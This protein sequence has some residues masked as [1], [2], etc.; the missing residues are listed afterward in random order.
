M[1]NRI[2]CVMLISIGHYTSAQD[3]YIKPG[4][5]AASITYSPSVMLNHAESNFYVTGFAEYFLDEHFSFRS[6]TY[7][8]LNS[9]NENSLIKDGARSYFGIAYHLNKGNWDGSIGFQ[10]GLTIMNRKDSFL[11]P[12]IEPSAALRIGTTYYVW[13]YFHF[14]ANLTYTRSKLTVFER[15]SLVTDEL[16]FSAGL[17]FQIATKGSKK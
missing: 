17:G 16:I 5:L 4:L 11:Q 1:V 7:L 3:Q 10:P 6:D 12:K 9:Q 13:K 15:G 14:F 8:F 2:L